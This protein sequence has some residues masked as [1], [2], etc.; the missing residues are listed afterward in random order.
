MIRVLGARVLVALPVKE[1]QQEASTGYTYQSGQTTASGLILAKPADVYN[2]ELATRG[3]VM[4][5][6]DKRG[7]VD[8]DD[9][10]AEINEFF[11]S[12]VEYGA[13]TQAVRI[14][15]DRLL[16][17]MAP[18]GFDVEVGDCVVFPASAGEQ[19]T[20]EDG[21]NYVLLHEED[22]IGVI[23]PLKEAAA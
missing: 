23:D 3:I 22:I 5:V 1:H 9:V 7:L 4:Q 10:R 18:A 20:Y 14:A 17:K 8:L 2:V 19:F 13:S 16:M 15:V 11:L 6:G 12:D 21:I